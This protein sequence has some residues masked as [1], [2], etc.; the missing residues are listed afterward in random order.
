[1]KDVSMSASSSA[2]SKGTIKL[3]KV[4]L[5]APCGTPVQD[6]YS[7]AEPTIISYERCR[8]IDRKF[9]ISTELKGWFTKPVLLDVPVDL[10]E[11][12]PY[13]KPG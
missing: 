12:T 13:R 2:S 7:E 8:F 3:W 6:Y 11:A 9:G 1:M 5:M 4:T 10:P